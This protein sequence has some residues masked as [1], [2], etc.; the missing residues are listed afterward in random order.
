MRTCAA[1]A[2]GAAIRLIQNSHSSAKLSTITPDSGSPIP[3][4]MPK[5]A[6]TMLRPPAIWSRG[7]VS[8]TIPNASGKT[9]PAT[10]CSTRPAITTSI[11]GASALIT[12]PSENSAST[13]VSIR[14]L[15]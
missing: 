6:L 13:A 9:P 15:P 8:R 4:P 3:P 11:V 5:I 10:P 2:A 7:N 1:T 14:P 12:A